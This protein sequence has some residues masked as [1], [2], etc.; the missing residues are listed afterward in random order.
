MRARLAIIALAGFV[1]AACGNA[2]FFT[3]VQPDQAPVAVIATPAA[4]Y[5][6]FVEYVADGAGSY[7]PDGTVVEWDWSVTQKPSA[8]SVALTA[9]PDAPPGSRVRFRPDLVGDYEITLVVKD[10][11]GKSSAPATFAFHVA[12]TSGL[13]VELTWDTN[14][15]DVDL[16]LVDEQIGGA[17]F[18]T[19]PGDCYFQDKNP[20]W[21]LPGDTSDDPVYP[22]DQDEGYGPESIGILAPAAGTYHVWTH[23][24]CDDGLGSTNATVRVFVDGSDMMESSALLPHT[25]SLWDV[26]T[27]DV[28]ADGSA[29]LTVSTSGITTTS[30]GC[31]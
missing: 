2:T 13:R 16:H 6:A 28:A 9:L 27:I 10:D 11:R 12:D 18:F 8:S 22:I 1:A 19:S 24:Y 21:G 26:A 4:P 5:D 29:T 14:I 15:T 3:K 7:D 31:T 20:D 17:D 23:Y 30:H 25:G